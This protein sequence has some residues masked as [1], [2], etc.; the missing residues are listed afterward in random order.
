MTEKKKREGKWEFT[1]YSTSICDRLQLNAHFLNLKL[2]E[3]KNAVKKFT[4]WNSVMVTDFKHWSI[5]NFKHVKHQNE[6]FRSFICTIQCTIKYQSIVAQ[7]SF[8]V[9]RMNR[10]FF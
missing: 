9:V 6:M 2:G 8:S 1:R 7:Y 4:E 5:I 3:E 10:I